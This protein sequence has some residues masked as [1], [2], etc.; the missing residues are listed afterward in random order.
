MSERK[1]RDVTEGDIG[2]QI[3]VTDERHAN[4]HKRLLGKI[5]PST[6]FPFETKTG[7]VWRYARIEVTDDA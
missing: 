5:N 6:R 4:W 2:K 1:F 7:A 3:E